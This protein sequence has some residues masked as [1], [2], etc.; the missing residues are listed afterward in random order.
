[1]NAYHLQILSLVGINIIMASS[2]GLISGIAGQFSLGHAGFMAVGAYG[3]ALLTS[4]FRVSL[5]GHLAFL[6]PQAAEL[7]LFLTSL[8]FGG[9]LSAIAGLVVGIPTLRL[10]GDYLAVMT[11][12]FGEIIRVIILNTETIGG[13]RGLSDIPEYA[14]PGWIFFFAGLTLFAIYRIKRSMKGKALLAIRDDEI[15]AASIGI[16]TSRYKIMAFTIGSFFAGLGGGLFAHLFT[17]L[18]TNSFSFARSIEFVAIIVLGGMSSLV[19]IVVAS[20][21]LTLL[22]EFLRQAQDWRMIIYALLLIVMMIA[23]ESRKKA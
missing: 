18:H 5:L 22:P 20:V 19:G 6:P 17:Y 15:A 14:G 12:G 7:L 4:V 21:L 10:K 16:P 23:R 11:L 9:C 2:L 13:A 8:L 3:A 1:M